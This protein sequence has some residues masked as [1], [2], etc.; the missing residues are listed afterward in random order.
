MSFTQS[1]SIKTKLVGCFS[2]LIL[3]T[4][5]LT[6]ISIGTI[7]NAEETA[8]GEIDELCARYDRTK[9]AIDAA[10]NLH[11]YSM[12]LVKKA[13]AD[14]NSRIDIS[15]AYALI[16]DLKKS[17]DALQMKRF[18]KE[19]GAVK[20][21]AKD[22]IRVFQNRLV[23]ELSKAKKHRRLLYCQH[24]YGWLSFKRLCGYL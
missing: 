6:L 13:R 21:S 15:D 4:V 1:W 2:F 20:E 7:Q 17:T 12:E 5:G 16:D 11:L 23:P 18:P 10:Y 19:I 9:K 22:Y 3:L 8:V 24:Y 14:I